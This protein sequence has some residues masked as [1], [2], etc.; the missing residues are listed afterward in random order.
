M[1]KL[2]TGL[3]H[4]QVSALQSEIPFCGAIRVVDQHEM[5]IVLQSFGLEFHGAAVLLDEFCED[6]LQQLGAKGNP[7]EEVPGSDDVN[8]ALVARDGRNGS[9]ARKPVF[10]GADD[11]RTQIGQNEIDGGGDRL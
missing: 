4:L 6:E 1:P 2:S 7:A 10:T 9:D 5:R 8:A 11:F 3:L